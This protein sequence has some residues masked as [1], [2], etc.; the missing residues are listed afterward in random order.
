MPNLN[1]KGRVVEG[2]NKSVYGNTT[3][4]TAVFETEEKYPQK[5]P[6]DFINKMADSGMKLD[7]GTMYEVDCNVNGRQ[8][9]TGKYFAS[10]NAWRVKDSSGAPAQASRAEDKV[11]F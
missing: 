9:K 3:V 2:P 7:N 11:P 8:A 6:V 10:I 1:F 4:V 5:I